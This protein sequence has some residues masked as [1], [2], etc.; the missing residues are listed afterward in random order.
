MKVILHRVIL[1]LFLS[2]NYLN[3]KQVNLDIALTSAKNFLTGIESESKK[4]ADIQLSY[5]EQSQTSKGVRKYFYVFNIGQNSGFIIVSA[6]DVAWP[7]LGYATEGHA[8]SVNIPWS[9]AKWLGGYRSDI[10]HALE[11][12]IIQSEACRLEWERLLSQN[13]KKVNLRAGS[14]SPL[15]TTKWNQSPYYNA[16]CPYDK[17]ASQL[18]VVGCVATAMAQVIRYHEYPSQ[19]TGF[20]SYNHSKYGS[21]AVNFANTTYNYSSMPT[22][23]SSA[24]NAVATLSY[25]CG[26]SVDMN[27]GTAASGGSG[28]YVI[29]S[30]SQSQHCAEYAFEEYFGYKSSLSGEERINYTTSSWKTLLKTE[31]DNSRPVLYAGFGSGGGHAFVLDGYDNSDYFHFNWGWGGAYD[32]YF[33]IDALNPTGVGT[34][35]GS[36]GFNSGH[37]AIIGIE[38]PTGNSDPKKYDLVLYKDLNMASTDVNFGAA[39]SISTNIYNKGTSSFS[40]DYGM[41]VFDKDYNFVDFVETKTGFTLTNGYVYSQDLVFSTTGNVKFLPG[42]YT[43]I[44]FYRPTSG[45]WSAVGENNGFVNAKTFNIVYSNLVELYSDFKLNTGSNTITRNKSLTVNVDVANFGDDAISGIIDVSLYNL[46]GNFVETINSQNFS[47]PSMTHFTGGLNFT[48]SS[49]VIAE[50]GSYL[51]AILYKPTGGSWTLVGSTNYQNPI[52][53]TVQEPSLL[54]DMYEANN[55]VGNSYTLPANY[56]SNSAKIVTSGSNFHV[57]TDYDYYKVELPAGYDYNIVAR[58]H[59]AN[60]NSNGNEYSVD[61]LL[62]VSSDGSIFSEAYDYQMPSALTIKNGGVCYIKVSPY[63]TGNIGTYLLDLNIQRTPL[64]NNVN[65]VITAAVNIYPNPAINN[66]LVTAPETIRTISIFS[67]EGRLLSVLPQTG[68][69]A[70][71]E[72]PVENYPN[73]SYL[74]KVVCNG[75]TYNEKFIISR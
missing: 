31:L 7:I 27:Y 53:V 11:N 41:A 65:P 70:K 64:S 32:G 13:N 52:S 75:I 60:N 2:F 18:T 66:I 61:A 37:Q 22:S 59:D 56:T 40:G 57:G 69:L 38:P 17:D 51:L 20:H 25:H 62:S 16:Q 55:T 48:L 10:Q 46:E 21:L 44:L 71:C 49:G 12:D 30:K 23:I 26:V 15:I 6:D 68:N 36:G 50:P 24:N 1:L 74:I 8:D 35:G 54:A 29:S 58:L 14:V 39:F 9:V 42:T 47:L 28:A 3:A 19:G 63:F 34:G 67:M 5:T 45:D 4:L 43:A 73:G 72:I 33:S